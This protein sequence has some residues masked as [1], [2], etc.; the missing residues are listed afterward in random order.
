MWANLLFER[1]NGG[2][3]CSSLDGFLHENGPV[4]WQAGTYLPVPNTWSWSNLTNIIYIDQPVGTGFSQGTPNATN[5]IDVAAQ[6]LPFW[7]NFME[8]FDLQERKVYIT[9]ESYAGQYCP[10]IAA[11]MLDQNDTCYYNV[12]GMM[13]YDPSIQW[14]LADEVAALP[15]IEWNHADFPFNTS[16]VETLK[17]QS[18]A[19]GY[20]KYI[21]EALTFPPKGHFA[22]PAAVNT[23]DPNGYVVDSCAIYESIVNEIFAINPCFD[24]YQVGQLCPL[25]WDVLGFPY[26][27]EYL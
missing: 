4:I 3:G 2:P 7:K 20:D 14:P 22:N 13:I 26:S 6:F 12:N 11:A 24:I 23:S 25:L 15:F 19:C 18:Q 27:N 17:N 10:Y 5:E 8:L 16:Y 1:L 9:G 21:E